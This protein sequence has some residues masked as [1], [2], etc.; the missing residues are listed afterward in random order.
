MYTLPMLVLLNFNFFTCAAHA[1]PPA[2]APGLVR[3]GRGAGAR[4]SSGRLP[5]LCRVG[6][7]H[8]W[9]RAG[10]GPSGGNGGDLRRTS[11]RVTAMELNRS[12]PRGTA[13]P[14]LQRGA[15]RC[16][17][18]HRVATP[19]V[20][21]AGRGVERQLRGRRPVPRR[22]R[23]LS[24]IVVRCII[25]LFNSTNSFVLKVSVVLHKE[26]HTK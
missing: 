18:V 22:R 23:H 8:G 24:R 19:Q 3:M 21:A 25:F 7:G 9:R 26:V 17:V 11:N 12:A 10:C 6:S 1:R 16:N 14:A 13:I 5:R 4:Q 20:R 15:P 2:P